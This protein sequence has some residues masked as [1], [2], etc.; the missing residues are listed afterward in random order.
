[1]KMLVLVLCQEGFVK[2]VE[3]A[4]ADKVSKVFFRASEKPSASV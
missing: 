3:A 1:M 4:T 2:P